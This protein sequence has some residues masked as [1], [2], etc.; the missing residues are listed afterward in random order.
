MPPPSLPRRLA[1][2][3]L[4]LNSWL[5]SASCSIFGSPDTN[6]VTGWG[7]I[8]GCAILALLFQSA[9]VVGTLD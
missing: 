5:K 1:M 4:W 2:Q 9:A 6:N 8:T 7:P 3:P